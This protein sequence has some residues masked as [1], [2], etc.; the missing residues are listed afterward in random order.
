MLTTYG[1]LSDAILNED[2]EEV[3][4]NMKHIVSVVS[5]LIDH[6]QMHDLS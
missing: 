4:S 5:W 6:V 2:Y 3:A 1:A